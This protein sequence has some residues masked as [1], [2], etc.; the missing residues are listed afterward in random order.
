MPARCN[1][2]TIALNSI[3]C[4]P[5]WPRLEYSLCGAKKPIES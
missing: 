1:I 4:S 3:T 5:P 2:F